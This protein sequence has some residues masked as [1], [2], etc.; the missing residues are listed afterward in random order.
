MASR[1]SGGRIWAG[2]LVAGLA[3]AVAA[4]AW[5]RRQTISARAQSPSA[6]FVQLASAGRT[7][8]DEVLRE[9]SELLDPTPLF[10]PTERNYGEQPLRERSLREPGQVSASFEPRLPLS[11]NGV[12]L[13]GGEPASA[14]ER[15]SD[16]LG[17]GSESTFAGF[18]RADRAPST[19]AVRSGYVE[20]QDLASGEVVINQAINGI[21]PPR[22]DFAPLE[23]LVV[24]GPAG[25]IGEPFLSGSSDGEDVENFFRSYLVRTYRLGERLRPGRYRVSVGA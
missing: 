14:P 6:S 9:R 19:L 15:L 23:F 4:V 1:A 7:S 24:V 11:E 22:R 16:V 21:D 3:V 2:L 8:T 13:Y 25:V 5:N 20:V 17:Q 12:A 10:F 18:G